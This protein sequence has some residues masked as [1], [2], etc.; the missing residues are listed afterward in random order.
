MLP[1]NISL[2]LHIKVGTQLLK[3]KVDIA[4]NMA[5]ALLASCL[6]LHC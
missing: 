5:P 3:C 1:A 4:F 6:V 2:Q